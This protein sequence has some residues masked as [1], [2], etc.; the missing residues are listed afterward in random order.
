MKKILFALALLALPAAF[1]CSGGKGGGRRAAHD[2]TALRIA[3][4]PTADCLPFYVAGACGLFDSAGVS[5]QLLTF[6]AAMDA[7]TAFARGWADGIATDAV[8]A[9][10][11]EGRGDSV[12]WAMAFDI[13]LHAVTARQARIRRAQSLKEKIVATTR[14]SAVA[15]T[16]DR[17]MAA[18]QLD[19]SELNQPQVNSIAL[20]AQMLCQNQ[21]DGAL[22]PEPYASACVARGARRVGS[23]RALNCARDMGTLLFHAKTA[24]D[25]KDDIARCVKAYDAAVARINRE[26]SAHPARLLAYLPTSVEC[27]DSLLALPVLRPA[28]QPND[29]LLAALRAWLQRTKPIAPPAP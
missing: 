17:L 7:D 21:Y 12:R 15:Y 1:S 2:S 16:A 11:W 26:A 29:S 3:V 27:P 25:R 24:A 6:G 4:L 18:A 9:L 10:A 13:D 22:L 8:K 14:N 23:S 28:S 5:V 19:A 20:R